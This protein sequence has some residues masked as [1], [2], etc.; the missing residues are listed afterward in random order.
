MRALR[1]AGILMAA[2]VLTVAVT[3]VPASASDVLAAKQPVSPAVAAQNPQGTYGPYTVVSAIGTCLVTDFNHVA[4]AATNCTG[5]KWTFVQAYPGSTNWLASV[6]Y[7]ISTVTG[8]CLTHFDY[9]H[10]Y[11]EPCADNPNNAEIQQ[12]TWT[13]TRH[14]VEL[15]VL[16]DMCTDYT[17]TVYFCTNHPEQ[18]WSLQNGGGQPPSN[19]YY[20]P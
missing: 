20:F 19:P 10:V 6:Y 12:W 8:W 9:V 16:E 4:Y 11:T 17:M 1:A 7:L 3:T 5:Q 18:T 13:S 14:L 15:A 2:V